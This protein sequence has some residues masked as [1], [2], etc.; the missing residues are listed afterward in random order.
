M[1]NSLKI[2]VAQLNPT[3][4]DVSGNAKLVLE[5]KEQATRV[6]ADLLVT[7][8]MIISGY[9]AEDLLLKNS[10]LDAVET[11]V[12]GLAEAQKP[13]DAAM[14]VGAPWRKDGRLYNAVHLIEDGE[15]TQTR[16]KHEL[17]NDSVFDEKRWFTPG[18]LSGPIPFKDVRLG[19]MICQDMWEPDV[20]ECLEESGA[21][22]LIVLNGS[23]F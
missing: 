12:H 22:M 15:I 9:P 19:V 4:G 14:L 3:V 13:G 11:E 5:A 2:A 16:F 20:A 6:G 18:P 1:T 17:P 23:P 8:E 21:E 7:P 10:F